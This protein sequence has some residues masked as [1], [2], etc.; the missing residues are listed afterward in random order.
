VHV[1]GTNGKGTVCHM[2]EASL[3]AS[4]H[5]TGLYT[6]P[7]LLD[8]RERIRIDGEPIG[9]RDL[10][11]AAS[12]LWPAIEQAD[13]T[14]F[15]ATTAIAFLAMAHAGVD[16][17]QR[18]MSKVSST[19]HCGGCDPARRPGPGT[20]IVGCRAKPD[21]GHSSCDRSAAAC[22]RTSP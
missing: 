13:A 9:E 8:F 14:F 2:I 20:H 15:E 18:R 19:R 6:S 10:L 17:A 12:R 1:A 5:R 21:A 22:S 4:G 7:H 3:R 16:V 11:D